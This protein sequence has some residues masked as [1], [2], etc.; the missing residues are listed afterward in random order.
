MELLRDL[1]SLV[2]PYLHCVISG[3][4]CLEDRNDEAQIRNLSCVLDTLTNMSGGNS[5]AAQSEDLDSS[6][7]QGRFPSPSQVTKL[8]LASDGYVDALARL[9]EKARLDKVEYV[10]EASGNFDDEDV[11]LW[12]EH[13]SKL[14]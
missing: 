3:V 12:S 7:Q 14:V 4:E 2:S 13:G 11:R 6:S 10:D 5:P 9:V 8:C 1:R